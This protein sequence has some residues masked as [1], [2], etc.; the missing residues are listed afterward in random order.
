MEGDIP[1]KESLIQILI[2]FQSTPSVWKATGD[3]GN[4]TYITTPISIHAFRVEGDD[5]QQFSFNAD[6]IFQSTPSVWKATARIIKKA[7]IKEISIHAFRV[8]G[9]G[10]TY[11]AMLIEFRFQSTPSVWKATTS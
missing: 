5:P 7:D 8:E 3:G 1:R 4:N 6:N 9:D 10:Q 11:S 2:L